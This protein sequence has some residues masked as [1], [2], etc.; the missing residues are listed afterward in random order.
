MSQEIAVQPKQDLMSA[1]KNSLYPGASDQA[2]ELVLSYCR[3]AG[4]DPLLK[5]VHIVPM[6]DAKSR[7]MKDTIM[8]G[9]GLYRIQA[10]RSDKYVGLSEPEFGP[11]VTEV[12]P[13]ETITKSYEGK[14][15]KKVNPEL[16]VTYPKWCKITVKKLVAAEVREY[17]ALEFWKENYA[18]AGKD[19]DQPNEMWRN[20][21][22]G[23]LAKCAE[24]QALRKAFP[25]RVSSQATA[26]E[27]EGKFTGIVVESQEPFT[28]P[29][30]KTPK[31]EKKEP[32][33]D[34]TPTPEPAPV[35][36][37]GVPKLISA[38]GA[39]AVLDI[40]NEK[41]RGMDVAKVKEFAGDLRKKYGFGSFPE[42]RSKDVVDVIADIQEW[43]PNV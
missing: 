41:A 5:P 36:N 9:I 38:E 43:D 21:P 15:T 11:D 32:T 3:A 29:K 24:A 42:I 40:W 19:S 39:K 7:S 2:C 6:Y 33:K 4:L 14:E 1:L 22:Y 27:M 25:D 16:K 23:Q 26:E 35:V 30:E 10:D 13:A 31:S 8:P 34:P 17:I 18:T 28:A 20:R 37:E 12:F